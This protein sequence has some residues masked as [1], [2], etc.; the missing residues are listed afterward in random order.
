MMRRTLEVEARWLADEVERSGF[1][2]AGDSIGLVYGWL[3]QCDPEAAVHWLAGYGNAVTLEFESRG[4][5]RPAFGP[6]WRAMRIALKCGCSMVRSRISGRPHVLT[7]RLAQPIHPG[8]DCRRPAL[9]ERLTT[10]GL[11]PLSMGLGGPRSGGVMWWKGPSSRTRTAH[12][13]SASTTPVGRCRVVRVDSTTGGP[14]STCGDSTVVVGRA[15]GSEF[16]Y[17]TPGGRYMGTVSSFE[18]VPVGV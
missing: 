5:M 18:P 17:T 1:H 10:R 16:S 14:D 9:S 3:W 11:M 7:L 8:G 6:L 4:W 12:L 15:D 13:N 2:Q